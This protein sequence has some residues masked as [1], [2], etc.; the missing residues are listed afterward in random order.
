MQEGQG[1]DKIIYS[2][3]TKASDNYMA[4]NTR[5]SNTRRF[6]KLS[7]KNSASAYSKIK[8]LVPVQYRMYMER[9]KLEKEIETERDT[10]VERE[11]EMCLQ[12]TCT[13]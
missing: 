10:D 13:C 5:S 12:T 1:I 9:R 8:E 11:R 4:T 2:Y 6:P 3:A 7:Q